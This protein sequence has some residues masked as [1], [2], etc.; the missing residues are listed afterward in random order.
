MFEASGVKETMRTDG[1]RIGALL[2]TLAC[3]IAACTSDSPDP[4][5]DQPSQA[6]ASPSPSPS[7]T[8]TNREATLERAIFVDG[9]IIRV[10]KERETVIA[11]WP[12]RGAPYV[13]P[14]ET[15]Y[16]FVGLSQE[17]RRLDLWLVDEKHQK[18]LAKD[19]GQSFAVSAGSRTVAYSHPVYLKCAK[20]TARGP[21]AGG[22]SYTTEL[23]T[24]ALP[25][26]SILH[27]R[28]RPEL[29]GSTGVHRGSCADK[30]RRRGRQ[31]R[32]VEPRYGT[33]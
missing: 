19:V 3:L 10:K 21:C 30:N 4:A 7:P 2:A 29:F 16:G 23:V 24:A 8:L 11:K 5:R 14:I 12:S 18:R 9:Q 28:E 15:N 32:F 22:G 26:G 6:L 1:R 27:T 33:C 25:S 17:R 13:P 20:A 31:C